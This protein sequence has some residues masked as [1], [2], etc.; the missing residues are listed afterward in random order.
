MVTAAKEWRALKNEYTS[1]VLEYKC[2][3][4]QNL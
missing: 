1:T 2:Q 4:I 3:I